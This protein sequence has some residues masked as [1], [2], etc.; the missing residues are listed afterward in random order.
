MN[1]VEVL[2]VNTHGR[3]LKLNHSKVLMATSVNLDMVYTDGTG[4]ERIG[5]Y[6]FYYN[7][8]LVKKGVRTA[9]LMQPIDADE[10]DRPVVVSAID[11]LAENMDLNH[12]TV[13]QGIFYFTQENEHL[14][15]NKDGVYSA[16]FYGKVLG[17]PDPGS[18]GIY[19]K[20]GLSICTETS[21]LI[22]SVCDW[23]MIEDAIISQEKLNCK[24]QEALSEFNVKTY[25]EVTYYSCEV[26]QGPSKEIII[27]GTFGEGGGRVF[28]DSIMYAMI[29]VIKHGW[30]GQLIIDNIRST[31]PKPGVKNSLFGIV[32]FCRQLTPDVKVKG[33]TKGSSHVSLD[34][35]DIKQELELE[36]EQEHEQG[37]KFK[38]DAN[39]MGSAWLLFLAVHPVLMNLPAG[40]AYQ[41]DISGGTDVYFGRDKKNK[42]TLTPPTRYMLDVWWP[43]MKQLKLF[44]HPHEI[45]VNV[46][47][48]QRDIKK[49]QCAISCSNPSSRNGGMFVHGLKDTDGILK[50]TISKTSGLRVGA[51]HPYFKF[52]LPEP[53]TGLYCDEHFAD[54]YIPYCNRESQFVLSD[55][56]LSAIYVK[57]AFGLI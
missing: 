11:K 24:V 33:L 28:R 5:I 51:A 16:L 14:F 25:S 46:V 29:S 1:H 27:D 6:E 34:F 15:C 42:R 10:K 56:H 39:G 30:R 44:S 32:D 4:K 3:F 37:F 26:Q 35:S 54:M 53:D 50:Y 12:Q 31:R 47:R 36:L 8:M 48:D 43:N 49:D 13:T 9:F 19:G 17:F 40:T 38:V 41:C 52:K 2:N 7:L 45:D 21:E 57:H 23:D 55:H 20:F 22:C 18:L